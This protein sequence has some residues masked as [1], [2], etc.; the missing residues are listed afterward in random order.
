MPSSVQPSSNRHHPIPPQL[1]TSSHPQMDN[2][3]SPPPEYMDMMRKMFEVCIKE[4]RE[5]YNQRLAHQ[6]QTFQETLTKFLQQSQNPFLTQQGVIP[7]PSSQN[8]PPQFYS[9]TKQHR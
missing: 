6:D 1:A 3:S 9:D 5:T 8:I 4:M 2:S 7:S